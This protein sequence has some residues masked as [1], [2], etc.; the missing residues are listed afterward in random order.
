MQGVQVLRA[1]RAAWWMAHQETT[2]SV[3]GVWD[4]GGGEPGSDLR[5]RP[6]ILSSNALWCGHRN[7]QSCS[8]T[9]R[10]ISQ[11]FQ[12]RV[13]LAGSDDTAP[14]ADCF[15]SSVMTDTARRRQ[16]IRCT[17]SSEIRSS[18]AATAASRPPARSELSPTAISAGGTVLTDVGVLASRREGSVATAGGWSACRHDSALC[19]FGSGATIASAGRAAAA[20]VRLAWMVVRAMV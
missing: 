4:D 18:R 12:I 20:L 8:G 11:P 13:P 10:G 14:P 16:R 15:I 5:P 6:M 19:S 1:G 7:R 17:E 9:V 2:R 3:G